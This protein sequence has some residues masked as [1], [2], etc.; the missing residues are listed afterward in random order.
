MSGICATLAIAL[1]RI[2]EAPFYIEQEQPVAP[3][4]LPRA[5]KLA[6]KLPDNHLQYAITWF[7][8]A[9]GYCGREITAVPEP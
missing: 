4:G 9:Q 5:G 6:V 2:G 1:V 3:G 7:G 8:L